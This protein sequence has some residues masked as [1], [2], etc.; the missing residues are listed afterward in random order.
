MEV[1]HA[2]PGRRTALP[3]RAD[4]CALLNDL[5]GD[6]DQCELRRWVLRGEAVIRKTALL[7]YLVESASSSTVIR[8]VVV[9][10]EMELSYAPASSRFAGRRSLFGQNFRRR[11]VPGPGNHVRSCEQRELGIE[12]PSYR[13]CSG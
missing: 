8:A 2:G 11:G 7:E 10:S 9:E 3:G 6:I 5:I 4:E 13:R 1:G 12:L